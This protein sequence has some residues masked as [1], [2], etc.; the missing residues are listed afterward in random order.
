MRAARTPPHGHS[1][2]WLGLALALAAV[3]CVKPPPEALVVRPEP[4]PPPLI[5]TPFPAP[6]TPLPS[7]V[8]SSGASTIVMFVDGV[9]LSAAQ[10]EAWQTLNPEV[11]ER[12][13]IVRGPAA[14]ARFPD[15]PEV[16]A[17]GAMLIYTRPGAPRP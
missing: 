6:G 13:E 1:G 8:R 4:A 7:V 2:S 3:S 9:R 10:R 15:D 14:A 5:V 11:V 16:Q 12:I 17:A